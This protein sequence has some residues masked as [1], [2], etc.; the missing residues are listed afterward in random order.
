MALND[1]LTATTRKGPADLEQEPT[2]AHNPEDSLQSIYDG[3]AETLLETS[4]EEIMEETRED[5]EDPI[6]KAEAIRNMLLQ[7]A[8]PQPARGRTLTKT[9]KGGS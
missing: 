9:G 6:K 3:I 2:H 8:N 4:D 5:G 7:I 1:G